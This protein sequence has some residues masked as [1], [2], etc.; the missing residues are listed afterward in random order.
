MQT[1]Y[2]ISHFGAKAVVG[3]QHTQTGAHMVD[4]A[5]ANAILQQQQQELQSSRAA[6][7]S[8]QND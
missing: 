4:G 3:A 7:A 5:V 1:A 6:A 2:C 8:E